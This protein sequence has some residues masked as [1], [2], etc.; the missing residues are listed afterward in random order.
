MKTGGWEDVV[1]DRRLRMWVQR[2]L[3]GVTGCWTGLG[4]RYVSGDTLGIER[5][6]QWEQRLK[7]SVELISGMERSGGH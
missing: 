6:E 1:R 5:P 4:D 7:K 2:G 3:C